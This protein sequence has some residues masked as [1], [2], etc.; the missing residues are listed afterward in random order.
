MAKKQVREDRPRHVAV[1]LA[2]GSGQ[3][4]GGEAPKQFCELAGKLVIEHTVEAFERNARIDDIVIVARATDISLVKALSRRNDW[5]KV[6]HV[7]EGGRER[8]YSCLAA[9]RLYENPLTR[10]LL[11]DAARPLVSQRVIDAVI[12]ALATHDAVAVA[13]PSTDTIFHVEE[14]HVTS[15]PP[16]HTLFRAQTPQAFTLGTI[17]SA[18]KLALADPSMRAT[19]DCGIVKRYLPDTPI[20]VV[21]GEDANMKLTYPGDIPL[22]ESYLRQ[23]TGDA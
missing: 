3:R 8:H 5:R 17:R 10:L 18:Y 9:I 21:P 14:D 4:A 11:H 15:I 19:D 20:L 16:R 13:I 6:A 22:L 12:D 23:A 2:G 1:V 7:V